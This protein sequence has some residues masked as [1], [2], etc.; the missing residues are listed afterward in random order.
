MTR[1]MWSLTSANSTMA[2]AGLMPNGAAGA[3]H[4]GAPAAAAIIAFEGTQPVLR[5]SP[6]IRPFS[7]NTTGTP[8]EQRPP[9]RQPGGARA[10]DAEIGGEKLGHSIFRTK[11]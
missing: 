3:K 9:H 6:P 4:L 5:C 11:M 1:W 2:L 8:S 10:D 7:I